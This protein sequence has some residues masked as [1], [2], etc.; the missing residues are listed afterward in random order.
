MKKR[1]ARRCKI[2]GAGMGAYRIRICEACQ[3]A[4][5]GME[6]RGSIDA[7]ELLT[8]ARARELFGIRILDEMSI[9]EIAALA[10]MWRAPYNTYGR[11]RGYVDTMGRLPPEDYRK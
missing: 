10:R 9:D 11:F 4:G 5:M 1:K 3:A 6:I 8:V 7:E 2:C